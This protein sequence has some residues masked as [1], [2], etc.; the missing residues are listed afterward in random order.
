MSARSVSEERSAGSVRPRRFLGALLLVTLV[1]A[2]YVPALSGDFLWDDDDYVSQNDTLRGV[3]GLSRMWLEPRS[4]PQYYPLVHTTFWVE[5][6]LF[7]LDTTAYH[8][9]NVL[10]H[11]LAA[12]LLWRVLRRLGV[13]GAWLAAAVF[14]LHPVH[15][16]SVAWITER[17]NVLSAALAFGAT[18]AWLRAAGVDERRE[19]R[20]GRAR[21]YALAVL[22][23]LGGLLSKTV[24][25][26]LPA[27]LALLLWWKGRLDRRQA[28]LLAP[29][30]LVGIAFGLTTAHL[31]SVHVGAWG[32]KWDLSPLD[33]LLI[34]GRAVWF[35]AGKLVWPRPL[36]FI[37]ERW[38]IDDRAPLQYLWPL[39]A[40]AL[41]LALWRARRRLGRGPLVAVLIF[42]GVLFPCLGFVDV[43]PFRFSFVADHFQY[44][45]S[46]A[47]IALFVATVTL[48]LSR[49]GARTARPLA[50]GV[51]LAL[52]GAAT[53]AR[54]HAYADRRTLWT[55]VVEQNPDAWIAHTNLGYELY[56]A[57]EH[58]A[59]TEHLERSLALFA[60]APET[61]TNLGLALEA[62]G[63]HAEAAALYAELVRRLPGN[64]K[65]RHDLASAL[66]ELERLDEAESAW[67]EA[68]AR[69]PDW[70]EA[71]AGL[72]A[73]HARMGRLDDARR[74]LERALQ[75][76]PD[77]V[78]ARVN[79]AQV[80]ERAGD[81]AA[82]EAEL[83]RVLALAPDHA[84]AWNN[85]GI[86]LARRGVTDDAA[87]HFARALAL[88]PSL[89]EARRNLAILRER[90]G[91]G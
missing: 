76:A 46:A 84:R 75:L 80:L 17:K 45:A 2:A 12:V 24:V 21:D 73:L 85:L 7:G 1:V 23:F 9:S 29:L 63:R 51:L 78:P 64:A 16:E 74:E 35:Y 61:Y 57:G 22:L 59:A 83:R 36:I 13:P 33:R 87:R 70:P 18:L 40:L 26:S 50:A 82:A 11:G 6:R 79:L 66:V 53:W 27:V 3:D 58:A 30:A 19:G 25:A 42:G 4:L 48:A 10:L 37:Y 28:L 86:L 77:L 65:A 67:N 15:V 49:P 54:A 55:D 31:E 38:E 52:L 88:D 60:D 39:A 8:V 43:Y 44:H 90:T 32:A 41:P 5:H 81:P 72:G 68:L 71:L 89:D 69:R 91:G 56:L 62:Q 20:G 34:A 14:G 47:L